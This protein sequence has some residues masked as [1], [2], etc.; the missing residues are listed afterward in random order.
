[1]SMTKAEREVLRVWHFS[2]RQ[3]YGWMGLGENGHRERFTKRK[4]L[5][6]NGTHMA[7]SKNA[8]AIKLKCSVRSDNLFER[9]KRVNINDVPEEQI[10]RSFLLWYPQ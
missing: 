5:I 3:L 10:S 1:M 7:A 8:R 4:P 9:R 6:A 2:R